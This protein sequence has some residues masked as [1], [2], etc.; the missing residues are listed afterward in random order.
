M[1]DTTAD[2]PA[3]P[4]PTANED[5]RR[6]LADVD[7]RVSAWAAAVSGSNPEELE[8]AVAK[9][10]SSPS[11]KPVEPVAEPP[12]PV[13]AKT[14][15][16]VVA[17]PAKVAVAPA[18]VVATPAKV[19]KAPAQV[20]PP[21]A[22]AKP[23]PKPEPAAPPLATQKSSREEDEALL[24][25]LDPETAQAIK[26]MR[27]MTFENKSV[28]QLLEEYE[29]ARQTQGTSESRKKSWWSRG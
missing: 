29:Q 13:V 8:R 5:I 12:A 22:P 26:V 10:A 25:T 4:P 27:R 19:V 15:A 7:A 14:P 11:S 6:A 17:A 16:K 18:K 24:A 28:R 23:E 3:L 2:L 9:P 1:S 20:A 21:P